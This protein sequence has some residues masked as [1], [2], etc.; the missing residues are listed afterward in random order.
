MAA[1]HRLTDNPD[2]NVQPHLAYGPDGGLRLST[3][4]TVS[5]VCNIE[6]RINARGGLELRLGDWRTGVSLSF[7]RAALQRFVALA[8]DLLAAPPPTRDQIGNPMSR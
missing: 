3:W 2:D 4:V 7:G 8:T 1:S 6:G 5:G